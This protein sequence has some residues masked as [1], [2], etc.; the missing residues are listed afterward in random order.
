[1]RTA[2]SETPTTSKNYLPKT[3]EQ[4]IGWLTIIGVLLIGSTGG[5]LYFRKKVKS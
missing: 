4:K 1:M 3:G 5:Y 2:R